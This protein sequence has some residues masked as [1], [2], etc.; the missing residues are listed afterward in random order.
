MSETIRPGISQCMIVKNEEKNIRQ[1]LTWGQGI[2]SEQIVV[3][4]G[5]DDRTVEIARQMGAKVYEFQWI[6][7]FAAAKNFAISKAVYEWIAFLD[8]DEYFTPEDAG[9][10]G[11]IIK[12]LEDDPCEAI[13]TG[14]IH[15]DNQGNVMAIQSQIRLFR[16]LPGLGYRRRIHEYLRTGDGR[17]PRL[18]DAVNELSIFHTGYGKAEIQKKSG[19]GRNLRLIQAE[20]KDN[21]DDYEMLWALGNEYEAMDDLKKAEPCYRR[22]TALMP[23]SM[24]GV[25][26]MSTSGCWLRLLE[27]LSVLPDADENELLKIYGKATKGWPQEGDFDYTMGN[28]YVAYRR[29]QEAEKHL[30]K[31]LELVEQYGNSAK[32]S[33]VSAD[34][35][36]TYELLAICC[37]NNNKLG[38]CVQLTTALLRQDAHLM[39]TL[40]VMLSAFARD[41]GTKAMDAAVFLG[42]NFYNYQI[43]GERIFVL[44]A[45]MAAGYRE[46]EEIIRGTFNPEELLAVDQALGKEKKGDAPKLKIVMFYSE[47]ESFN[48][49]TEQL[50]KELQARGHETLILDL[51]EKESAEYFE[52]VRSLLDSFKGALS[53]K[54]HGVICFDG[55]GA[56][57]E[58]WRR[59]WDGYQAAVMDIFMDPPL[60]FRPLLEH[61]PK[62][63]ELFCCDREHV[64]YVKKYYGKSVAAVD[65]MPHVGVLPEKKAWIPYDERKYDILFCGTYYK[66]ESKMAEIDAQC[67][68]DSD[69]YFLYHRTFEFLKTNNSLSAWQGFLAVV[70]QLGWNIP[71]EVLK[72][73]LTLLDSLDWAIRMYQ[74]ERVVSALAES[75]LDIYLLGRGWEN[76]PA[77]DLPNVHR[78]D[79]RIPYGETL[80]CMADARI[81]LNVMPG[82]KKGTHDRIFNT[83]LQGSVPLTDSSAWI[84]ENFSDGVD[85][86]LYDLDHLEELPNIARKLLADRKLAEAII[87]NGYEKTAENYTWSHCAE[88]ILNGLAEA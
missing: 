71:E 66:P 32:S 77:A 65:F 41:K 43:L 13:L 35:M 33:F 45:A 21:P 36:K 70:R 58:G 52:R 27:L 59:I 6:D 42:N 80:A 48:F 53:E 5:S 40:T 56:R 84:D 4:T 39:S 2:V 62:K 74:R 8:A 55:L 15:L 44:R 50:E 54:I 57:G 10:L 16:N 51:R 78:I 61:P 38:E 7:D 64:E 29:Y 3:D 73:M 25:Y 12:G 49:F 28:Y 24:N 1:A 20:L 76:H 75:G 47:V 14:W 46:L 60:R 37:F 69:A 19:Q 18:R 26:D 11:N 82:F 88:W 85:I 68:A 72:Q 81:N 30:R 79:D 83:L 17:S 23:E 63:Y 9:K 87:E 67:P 22:A 31:A 86:A 34:I